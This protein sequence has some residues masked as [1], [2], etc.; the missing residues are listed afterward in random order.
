MNHCYHSI[1]N[2]N[3]KGASIISN[4]STTR[5]RI[6]TDKQIISFPL[7]E[8]QILSNT[9]KLCNLYVKGNPQLFKEGSAEELLKKLNRA[10]SIVSEKYQDTSSSS[11]SSSNNS[12][13]G[14]SFE[15]SYQALENIRNMLFGLSLSN[16]QIKGASDNKNNKTIICSK[17]KSLINIREHFNL[18]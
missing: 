15:N 9:L 7:I 17:T 12:I 13:K 18:M 4:I 11:S 1:N 16:Q 8:A 3:L 10:Q 14:A 2:I 6:T 5:T